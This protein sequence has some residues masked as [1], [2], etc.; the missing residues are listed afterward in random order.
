VDAHFLQNI[1]LDRSIHT[2]YINSNYVVPFLRCRAM[3]Q[4]FVF[5]INGTNPLPSQ[6][7]A[8]GLAF[9][10]GIQIAILPSAH[11]G[12]PCLRGCLHVG[13]IFNLGHNRQ[14]MWESLMTSLFS[15]LYGGICLANISLQTASTIFL[16]NGIHPSAER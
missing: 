14:V 4:K 16:R 8:L 10:G 7:F 13:G 12:T 6:A 15:T 3:D 9:V 5:Q 2:L 1:S 11:G